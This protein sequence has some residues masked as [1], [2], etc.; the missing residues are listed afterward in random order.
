MFFHVPKTGGESINEM[1][2]NMAGRERMRW[3]K[4]GYLWTGMRITGLEP[5]KQETYLKSM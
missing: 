3:W 1:W 2:V 5:K 4:N